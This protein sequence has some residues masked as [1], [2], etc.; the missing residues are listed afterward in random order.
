MFSSLESYPIFEVPHDVLRHDT[1]EEVKAYRNDVSL[2][3]KA[4]FQ[5]LG[6][7]QQPAYA[8]TE[9]MTVK[10]RPSNVDVTSMATDEG[11]AFAEYIK[12]ILETAQGLS[13]LLWGHRIEA[14][15]LV[16]VLLRM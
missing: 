2:R 13:R 12:T 3:T 10:L 7:P 4:Q 9:I 15:E 11:K 14:P 8:F 1:A 5:A 6:E 16:V